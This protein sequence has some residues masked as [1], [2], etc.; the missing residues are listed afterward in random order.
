MVFRRRRN[1]AMLVV[2]AIIPVV[3]ATAVKIQN[4]H[5][6]GSENTGGSLIGGI[7][8]NGIF[9][10]FAGLFVVLTLFLP[11]TVSVVSGD[12]IAGE[13]SA[14]TL[15]YLLAV[16]V[17]RTR[18]LAVKYAGILAWCVVAPAVVAVSG[19][20]V[21]LLL[22]PSGDITLLSGTQVSF[23]SAL[24]RLAL[25]VGYAAA[26]VANLGAIGLFVSTLTEVPV[27]AMA[28][29]LAVSITSEVLD[30]VPQLHSIQPWLFSHYWLQFGDL[31]RDPL[32]LGGVEHGV[33]V[34]L[35]YAAVF[36]SAAWARFGEKDITS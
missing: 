25:V 23:V 20:G 11:M 2:L 18:L 35:A 27:A 19:V 7:T 36:L 16:P 21:G 6:R 15:R 22:F 32:A 17:G 29:T 34:S 13:A 31:L 1:L 4:P 30:S 26:M 28:T 9:V 5:S 10:A 33:L 24:G 3:I 8:Q 14:G 12:A